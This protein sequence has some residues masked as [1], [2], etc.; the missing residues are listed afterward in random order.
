MPSGIGFPLM[1]HCS[2]TSDPTA[3]TTSLRGSLNTGGSD[4]SS[5]AE[6]QE[7]SDES[8]VEIKDKVTKCNA[9]SAL[10]PYCV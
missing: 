9:M 6:S 1:M 3:A 2:V 7:S 4:G 8:P 10:Q 5:S